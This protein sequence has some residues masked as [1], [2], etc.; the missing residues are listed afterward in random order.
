MTKT[1]PK[2][3][4]V[5]VLIQLREGEEKIHTVDKP[6]TEEQLPLMTGNLHANTDSRE[7]NSSQD[8]MFPPDSVEQL[9]RHY[10]A[11]DIA[12]RGHTVPCRL[13]LVCERL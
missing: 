5:Q 7:D 9:A 3:M 12:S 8:G 2:P 4:A 10:N 13:I 11:K 6:A 1:I